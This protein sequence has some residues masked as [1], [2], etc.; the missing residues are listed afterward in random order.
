MSLTRVSARRRFFLAGAAVLLLLAAI[1][2]SGLQ[3]QLQRVV[4]GI[5]KLGSWG[6]FAFILLYLVATVLFVPGSLLTLGAGALFGVVRGSA[7]VLSGA[8]LGATCAFLIARYLA[9]GWVARKLEANPRCLALDKAIATEGWKIVGLLRL[10]PVVPFNLLN[11]ALG[12]TRVSLR[13]YFFASLIG[14]LPGTIMY[15]YAGALLGDLANL[16]SAR[17][18]RTLAEWSLYGAGLLA[19]VIAT[20]YITRIA[21]RALAQ[22]VEEE[23]NPHGSN[24]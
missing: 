9:R 24:N 19:T 8:M 1:R 13:D 15:V 2:W 6:P 20:F 12:L 4:R 18:I 5:G 16:S 7:I 10:S 23:P 17:R 14:M 3:E 21:R 11:Y 22:R